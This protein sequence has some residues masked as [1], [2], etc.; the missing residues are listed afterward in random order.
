MIS[1]EPGAWTAVGLLE[2]QATEHVHDPDPPGLPLWIKE[3]PADNDF[4]PLLVKHYVELQAD[5]E[6]KALYA[7]EVQAFSAYVQACEADPSD[8]YKDELYRALYALSAAESEIQAAQQVRLAPFVARVRK[9]EEFQTNSS[10]GSILIRMRWED[11]ARMD[12]RAMLGVLEELTD[13]KHRL[14]QLLAARPAMYDEGM[15]RYEAWKQAKEQ[16]VS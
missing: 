2:E 11:S 6:Y 4:R 9:A 8:E 1:G 16:G 3:L 7:T 12:A 14:R 5:N 13:E 10:T 15:S